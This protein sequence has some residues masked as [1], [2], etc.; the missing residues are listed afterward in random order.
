MVWVTNTHLP[1]DLR[2][3]TVRDRPVQKAR[4][5]A[6]IMFNGQEDQGQIQTV[7]KVLMIL[8]AMLT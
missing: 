3:A 1:L 7:S 2:Q 5:Q 8:I 4:P 6:N